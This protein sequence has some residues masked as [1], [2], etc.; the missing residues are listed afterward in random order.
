MTMQEYR[1]SMRIC[2]SFT[3]NVTAQPCF[4]GAHPT[5]VQRDPKEQKVYPVGEERDAIGREFRQQPR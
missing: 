4:F 2:C 5:E 3:R 1:L